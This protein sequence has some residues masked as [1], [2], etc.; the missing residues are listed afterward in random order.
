MRRRDLL[1]LLGGAA[2]AWPQAARA[3]QP[4]VPV[5][6]FLV[7][8]SPAMLASR[9][10]A[11]RRGLGETG[12]VEGRNVTIEYRWADSID[13]VPAMAADLVRR[14]VN[15]IAAIGTAAAAK[16]ATTTIPIVF[17]MA[18]DPV[19]FGLVNSLNRPGGNITGATS[20]TVETGPKQLEVLHELIPEAT[21]V[22]LLVNPNN[23]NA[24]PLTQELRTAAGTL[25]LK[26]QVLN[27]SS[28]SD[29]EMVLA[30]LAARSALVI[31][32]DTLFIAQAGQ[33]AALTM[34]HAVPA[35]NG[36]REFVAA[37]GLMSYGGS[38]TEG[39]RLAGVWT[40]RV[41][42][43]ERPADL[44]VQQVTKIELIINLKT[45]KALGIT[46]PITLLG[47]ADEVIE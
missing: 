11:F 43:G 29:L 35:I 39:W 47:R 30:S 18:G 6:G 31:A 7:A 33:L 14:R 36:N 40:G 9:L 10:D 2:V 21:S 20:M 23:A 38:S 1:T 3:Q 24:E 5:I 46:V 15:V 41:L 12:Y 42:K 25:G 45:A 22:G 19:A 37:G 28:E 4:A 34:R 17:V 16:A 44:P 27:A 26:L 32:P 13:R 8:A